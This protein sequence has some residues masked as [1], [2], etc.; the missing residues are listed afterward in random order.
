MEKKLGEDIG[1]QMLYQVIA[2]IMPLITAPYISRKLGA[3]NL[4]IFSYTNSIVSYFSLMARISMATYGSRAVANKK[5]ND[6]EQN[7]VFCNLYVLQFGMG[8]LT[9][10]V[11]LLCCFFVFQSD[12]MMFIL[13]GLVLISDMMDISWYYFGIE[14]FKLTTCRSIWI[15]VITVI[16]MLLCVKGNNHLYRYTIIINGFSC[17]SSIILWVTLPKYIK[18]RRVKINI[19]YIKRQIKP[20]LI[21]F[22]PTIAS[23]VYHMMDKTMLGI[24]STYDELGFYYNSDKLINIPFCIFNG[25]SIVMMPK[26][27]EKFNNNQK[28]EAYKL[29]EKSFEVNTFL[30]IAISFGIG[31]VSREFVPLFFGEGYEKCITLVLYFVPVLLVKIFSL[32]VRMQIL[33]PMKRDRVYLYAVLGGVIVNLVT[34]AILIQRFAST[35]A[36]IAT[37]I[38]EF[39]VCVIQ[40][41][42]IRKEFPFIRWFAKNIVYLLAGLSMIVTVRFVARINYSDIVLV[43]FE[44]VLGGCVYMGVL[45][46]GRGLSKI[47]RKKC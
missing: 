44:I 43:I 36:V 42:P 35:G 45:S 32:Y 10:L 6:K 28:K 40:I 27:S 16:I 5:Q 4:G 20:L 41:I 24:Y 38:A 39:V 26:I 19:E 9:S 17:I 1:W 7:K 13:Q 25:L 30:G 37:F 12:R 2:V 23:S 18:E 34:N 33:I 8:V 29:M 11:Y 14:E 21:L 47:I 3:V 31:A 22:V 46:G 15:K